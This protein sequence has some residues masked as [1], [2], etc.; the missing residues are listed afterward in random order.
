MFIRLRLARRLGLLGPTLRFER[1]VE[2]WAMQSPM[3][4][5]PA[6]EPASRRHP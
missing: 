3:A 5:Q 4:R 6:F 2:A 1:R